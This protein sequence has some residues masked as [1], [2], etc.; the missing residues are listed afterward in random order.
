M[1]RSITPR[2]LPAQDPIDRLEQASSRLRQVASDLYSADVD[3]IT[4]KTEVHVHMTAPSAPAQPMPSQPDR[5]SELPP[6]P[7]KRG[8][9]GLLAG[10]AGLV[11]AVLAIA[12]A[13]GWL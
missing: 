6:L 3:E 13:L 7:V 5:E 12:K 1:S 4:Q 8:A 2:D 10:V 11:S 9:G